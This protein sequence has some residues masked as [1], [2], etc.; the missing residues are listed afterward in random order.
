MPL[1]VVCEEK[2]AIGTAWWL[3]F[4]VIVACCVALH[5]VGWPS[6]MEG[7]L[8]QISQSGWFGQQGWWVQAA[9]WFLANSAA[10][11]PSGLLPPCLFWLI[12]TLSLY[13]YLV[14]GL[15]RFLLYKQFAGRNL[16]HESKGLEILIPLH[17]LKLV[18]WS[19]AVP[20]ECCLIEVIFHLC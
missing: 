8:S 14:P 20:R 16:S 5:L 2:L 7:Q 1:P 10:I 15:F 18:I 6:V 11:S 17:W 9:R 13:S 19:S 3:R 4:Q 12:Y